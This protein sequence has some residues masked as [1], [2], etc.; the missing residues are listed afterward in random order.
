VAGS[1][2]TAAIA[3]FDFSG[4]AAYTTTGNFTAG[5]Y[6]ASLAGDEAHFDIDD[7][8]GSYHIELSGTDYTGNEAGLVAAVNSQLATAGSN[9]TVSSGGAGTPLVLA[10]GEF[11]PGSVAPTI[12]YI[13]AHMAASGLTTGSSTA[14]SGGTSGP[15]GFSVDGNVV[16]LTSNTGNLAGL[17]SA[18]DGQLGANYIV[19]ASGGGLKI[20]SAVAGAAI[21]VAIGSFTGGG[22]AA[23]GTG[24]TAVAGADGGGVP[25]TGFSLL[26]I[27]TSLG[28]HNAIL[29]MDAA[30]SSVNSA[31]GTL[32]AIQSRF[33]S[34]VSNIHIQ[35]E[36]LS[37]ARSRIVDAD[38]A[39][40]TASLTRG[41]ILQQAGTAMLAQ[42]N[43]L[44]NNV[45]SLLR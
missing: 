28:A 26:D 5:N 33:E 27:S 1:Y 45:L 30:L 13:G 15:A 40:E 42:A 16:S 17:V 32:G 6:T 21:P 20:E 4:V 36:N 41:Q 9:T 12:T 23:F 44:P 29:A 3:T 37:A 38:F 2:T 10:S 24:A 35:S 43:S 34:A 22:S 18:V 14:G 39:S 7:D 25:Q 11:G 19:S 31:R 8:T